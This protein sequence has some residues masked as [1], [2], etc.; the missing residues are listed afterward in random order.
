MR[1]RVAEVQV[2]LDPWDKPKGDG[3]RLRIKG[4]HHT[5]L[6]SCL[7]LFQASR[8]THARGSSYLGFRREIV[9]GDQ[10]TTN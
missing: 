9:V 4:A 8:V 2:T 6:W 7:G 1:L 10:K 3:L 5:P